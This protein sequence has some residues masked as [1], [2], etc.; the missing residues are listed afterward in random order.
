MNR[1]RK[2]FERGCYVVWA[3]VSLFVYD[4]RAIAFNVKEFVYFAVVVFFG[5]L[6]GG[7][8]TSA[9]GLQ[10]TDIATQTIL[11][12]VPILVIYVVWKNYAQ[13]KAKEA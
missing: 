13:K 5:T 2:M 3:W 9:A 11:F 8:I 12:L 4:V 10:G 7:Y 6:A 1:L